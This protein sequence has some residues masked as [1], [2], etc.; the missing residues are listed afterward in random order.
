MWQA[1]LYGF[2]NAFFVR[3]IFG[4]MGRKIIHAAVF[5]DNTLFYFPFDICAARYFGVSTKRSLT[6]NWFSIIR[7][8][9]HRQIGD[10]WSIYSENDIFGDAYGY[11]A[12]HSRTEYAKHHQNMIHA[13]R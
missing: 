12:N 9:F 5:S 3:L 10:F 6:N 2:N 1:F 8:F 11:R 7:Y 4:E 13:D